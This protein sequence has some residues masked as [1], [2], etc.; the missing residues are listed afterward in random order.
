MKNTNCAIIKGK[1]P[2]QMLGNR[3]QKAAM[4]S[5]IMLS[6]LKTVDDDD[7][8]KH[9]IEDIMQISDD[10]FYVGDVGELINSFKLWKKLLPNVTPYYA[11]KCNDELNII[12]VLA[13]LGCNF[14]CASQDELT[15]V[16]SCGVDPARIIF[17]NP[18]KLRTH[19][20]YAARHKV[21]LMTF[22][23][24]QELEKIKEHH[25]DAKLLVRIRSDAKVV[26]IQMGHKFG[27][28]PENAMQLIDKAVKMGLRIVG[29][30]FHVGTGC[31][32]PEAFPRA[33]GL[34]AKILKEAKM[35][36]IHLNTVDVGGGFPE[37]EPDTFAKMAELLKG[38]LEEQNDTFKGINM[39]AEPGRYFAGSTFKLYASIIGIRHNPDVTW[40][41]INRGII[42]A[43]NCVFSEN[44]TRYP[45]P[46]KSR[47]DNLKPS[48]IWG[49]EEIQK[50][51]LVKEI[52]LPPLKDGDWLVFPTMG[53]YTVTLDPVNWLASSKPKVYYHVSKVD[54]DLVQEANG[55]S[56][57][58]L[59][60]ANFV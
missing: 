16:L 1:S 24:E 52:L 18:T 14:D 48:L 53:A 60:L 57:E 37:N 25:P 58:H 3:D 41:Y 5:D 54:W 33:I 32:E 15:R 31:K 34:C 28:T 13:A 20:I 6:S 39:I 40:Y 35:K 47:S 44:L 56:K 11:V 30:A 17:A 7:E 10:S 50:D 4:V 42:G 8:L 43:F 12:K 21:Q 29:I 19:L 36:G 22:D 55:K 51:L 23:T 9:L 49:P 38:A 2:H 46:W 26:T 27:C 59:H 45:I